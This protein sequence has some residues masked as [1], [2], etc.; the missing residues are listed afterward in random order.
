MHQTHKFAL[1]FIFYLRNMSP[2]SSSKSVAII[3][4]ERFLK[5]TNTKDIHLHYYTDILV[6]CKIIRAYVSPYKN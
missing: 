1:P 2:H 5:S 3:Y 6:V 4:T